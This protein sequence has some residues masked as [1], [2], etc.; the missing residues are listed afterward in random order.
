MHRPRV[1]VALRDGAFAAA[2]ERRPALAGLD[3]A[4]A[5]AALRCQRH[6]A[7]ASCPSRVQRLYGKADFNFYIDHAG[8]STIA[9]GRKHVDVCKTDRASHADLTFSYAELV[10][11]PDA[12][13]LVSIRLSRGLFASP[14]R[15]EGVFSLSSTPCS[16]RKVLSSPAWNIWRTMSEPPTNSPFT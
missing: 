8:H 1:W 14:A 16:A 11:S 9:F 4:L 10:L 15:G 13:V 7:W 12:V 2:P 5:R 6:A 3:L